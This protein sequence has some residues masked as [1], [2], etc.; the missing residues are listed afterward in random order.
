MVNRGK[1]ASDERQVNNKAGKYGREILM[2]PNHLNR[3]V[4]EVGE[5]QSAQ[6]RA[7]NLRFRADFTSQTSPEIRRGVSH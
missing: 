1:K 5:F 3:E 7:A 2:H 4:E 6:G